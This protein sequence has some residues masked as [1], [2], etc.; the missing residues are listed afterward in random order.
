MIDAPSN[1]DQ[2]HVQ[3]DNPRVI[4]ASGSPRRRA[5]LRLIG[6]DFTILVPDIDEEPYP[7]E[8]PVAYA[9]RA[10]TTKAQ[11]IAAHGHDLPV[12]SADTVVAIDGQILGKPTSAD[13]AERMLRL[14]A[15]TTHAVHT[16]MAMAVGA[17]HE[18][19]VDSTMVTFRPMTDT[20]ISWYVSSGEPMDKAGAYGVQG[21]G[22]LFVS[23]VEGSPHTVV[24]LPIHR[25]SELYSKLGLD[26]WQEIG[27]H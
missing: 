25:L 14:L 17:K 6:L 20:E 18:V 24:G 11:A 8:D 5:M 12:I 3:T 10:A 2:E 16:S 1:T 21:I 9:R 7:D 19:I 23:S 26:L 27:D 4:L 22:G 13:D 15:G